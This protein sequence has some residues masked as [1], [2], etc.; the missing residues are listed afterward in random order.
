MSPYAEQEVFSVRSNIRTSQQR[1]ALGWSKGAL[2]TVM[3]RAFP[4]AGLLSVTAQTCLG[5]DQR[6]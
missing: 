5:A 6:R 3:V 4:A 2:S 1:G